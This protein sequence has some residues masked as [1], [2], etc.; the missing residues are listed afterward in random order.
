MV[1]RLHKI[2]SARDAL[3]Q[4]TSLPG[5]GLNQERWRVQRGWRA[6]LRDRC[7]LE[8][9]AFELDVDLAGLE[10]KTRDLGSTVGDHGLAHRP[11]PL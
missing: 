6:R 10:E 5:L 7:P 8:S 2:A 9:V 11:L 4:M 1:A 3:P